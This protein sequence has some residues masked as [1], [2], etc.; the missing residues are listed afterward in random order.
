MIIREEKTNL[1]LT[2][3]HDHALLS[4]ALGRHFQHFF[5][6]DPSFE[7]ALFAIHEHDRSWIL[8][9]SQPK[10]NAEKNRPYDFIDYPQEEKLGYYKLGL[11]ETEEMNPYAALLCSMHYC[12]FV[13]NDLYNDAG[14]Q[15]LQS[16]K[17][18]QDRILKTTKSFD[19]DC[20]SKE[21]ALLQLCDNL[22]LYLCLN[23]PGVSK[24]EEHKFFMNGFKNSALFNP[25]E[26]KDLIA[27]WLN[28]KEVQI[29]PFPFCESF[30]VKID[31]RILRKDEISKLGLEGAFIHSE[32]EP[33][34]VHFVP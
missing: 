31:Q 20:L 26:K 30:E 34:I 21:F 28:K 4:G 5:A 9:D 14:I 17:I 22:S 33:L 3:Q 25:K 8:P 2:C 24:N 27:N 15:F 6:D 1:I 29:V 10:W 13:E 18:R 16:E 23:H 7:D 11:N 12:S 32:I 19:E